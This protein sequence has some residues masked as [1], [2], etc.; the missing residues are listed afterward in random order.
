LNQHP[1]S[2]RK[3]VGDKSS[4]QDSYESQRIFDKVERPYRKES[5]ASF[6]QKMFEES[7]RRAQIEEERK[8][9]NRN[10]SMKTFGDFDARDSYSPAIQQKC[11]DL[12]LRLSSLIIILTTLLL[13]R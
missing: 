4:T 3:R 11:S 13:Q 7:K 6:D 12:L 5:P 9:N 8:K 10:L 2:P 1:T